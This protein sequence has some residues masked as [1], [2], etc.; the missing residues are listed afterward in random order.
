M[1]GDERAS[2]EQISLF[3]CVFYVKAERF[4]RQRNW[5]R[6]CECAVTPPPT[7]VNFVT[8]THQILAKLVNRI[9]RYGDGGGGAIRGTTSGNFTNK[10]VFY[11]T[12]T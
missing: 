8:D 5:R 9:V 4:P 11:R 12:L 10:S 7:F 2:P 1:F 6:T 3:W